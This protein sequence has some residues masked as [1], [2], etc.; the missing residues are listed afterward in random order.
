MTDFYDTK[1]KQVSNTRGNSI[2]GSKK[3][4]V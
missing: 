4:K 1:E 2:V 3:W